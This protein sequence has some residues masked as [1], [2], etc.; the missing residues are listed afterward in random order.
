MVTQ[1]IDLSLAESEADFLRRVLTSSLSD[2][3]MEIADT[4]SPDLRQEL[5]ADEEIIKDLLGKVG[6]MDGESSMAG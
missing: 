5:K 2:V 6:W 3:R 4:E 1:V